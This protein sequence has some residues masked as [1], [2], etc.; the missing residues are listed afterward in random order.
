MSLPLEKA[1]SWLRDCPAL[2]H[3]C[4]FFPRDQTAKGLFKELPTLDSKT[5]PNLQTLM[6][7]G[8]NIPL[9]VRSVSFQDSER[10]EVAHLQDCWV[11][12]LSLPPCCR[13]CVSTQVSNFIVHMDEAR[14]HLLVSKA[15]YLCLP[16][17]LAER[18]APEGFYLDDEFD[19]FEEE[20]LQKISTPDVYKGIPDMYPALRSL[21]LTWPRRRLRPIWLWKHNTRCLLKSYAEQYERQDAP[22]PMRCLSRQ[23]QHANLRELLIE[24]ESLVVT[25]PALPSLETLLVSCYEYVELDFADPGYLGRTIKSMSIVGKRI[26]FQVQQHE[27]LCKALGSRNLELSKDQSGCVHAI[28]ASGDPFLSKAELLEQARQGFECRCG[29]CPSCLGIGSSMLN[30]EDP[31]RHKPEEQ[32]HVSGYHDYRRPRR[33]W[34]WPEPLWP[35]MI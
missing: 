14:E 20:G 24:G 29:A 17:D 4:L 18:V 33:S 23:W 26:K 21:R 5:L 6:L 10:L 1:P 13:I 34:L 28:H 31:P 19:Q 25:I 32:I 8:S 22:M 11:E 12:D 15:S 9:E 7:H 35:C 2:R 27:D 30:R 16:N 3:L